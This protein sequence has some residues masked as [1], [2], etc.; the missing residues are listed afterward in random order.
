MITCDRALRMCGFSNKTLKRR[1]G[2]LSVHMQS[3]LQVGIKTCRRKMKLSQNFSSHKPPPVTTRSLLA[4]VPH[5]IGGPL[6]PP[7]LADCKHN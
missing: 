7:Q 1:G 3:L 6:N 5:F 4:H 2:S